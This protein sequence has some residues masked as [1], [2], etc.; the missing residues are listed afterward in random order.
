MGKRTVK[1]Q[2]E[3]LEIQMRTSPSDHYKR[4]T[5]KRD[6]LLERIEPQ[7]GHHKPVIRRVAIDDEDRLVKPAPSCG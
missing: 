3:A 6:Q 1:A 4:L 2:L 5:A 7:R